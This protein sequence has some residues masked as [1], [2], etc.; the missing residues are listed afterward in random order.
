MGT[1]HIAVALG[2]MALA[3]LLGDQPMGRHLGQV[4]DLMG[5]VTIAAGGRVADPGAFE[6]RPVQGRPVFFQGLLV[7][8]TA[9][10]GRL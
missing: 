10:S 5:A 3:A 6:G 1:G 8:G 9:H 4:R 7:A 2:G